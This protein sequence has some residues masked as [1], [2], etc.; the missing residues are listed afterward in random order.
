MFF[1]NWARLFPA[2][3]NTRFQEISQKKKHPDTMDKSHYE[4]GIQI[5]KYDY[6]RYITFD[7]SNY[8]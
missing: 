7:V 2:Q 5:L 1:K 8:V 3:D 4:N 6:N